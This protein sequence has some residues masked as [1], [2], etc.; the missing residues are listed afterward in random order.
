MSKFEFIMMFVSVVVAFAMSELLMG[1]G[2]LVRA[3]RR[4]SKPAFMIGWSV[5]L[6]AITNFH[7]LGFWEYG[8]VDFR[9][10]AQMLLFLAAPIMLV[11]V[12]FVVTPEVRYY[13]RLDLEQ[14]YFKV[15]NWFFVMVILFFLLARASDPLL[16][17]YRETWVIRSIGTFLIVPS[18]IVLLFTNN[19]IVHSGI[20][21]FN[22]F[23]LLW[24]S[25]T[26]NVGSL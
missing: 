8:I 3:R 2:R 7:Y 19:R 16:P 12:T 4:I 17:D 26:I 24:S 1:W 18:L 21:G 15:K 25:Y 13:Q 22:L 20:L 11:L 14:H 5:W 6:L 9:T 10:A 23:L